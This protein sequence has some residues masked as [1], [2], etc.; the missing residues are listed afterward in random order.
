[1]YSVIASDG[2]QYGPVDLST[3]QQWIQEGRIV[4]DTVILDGVTGNRGPA[5]QFPLIAPHLHQG[6][7]PTMYQPQVINQ[8]HQPGAHYPGG[9]AYQ[10]GQYSQPPNPYAQ[11]PRPG[12]QAYNPNA[13]QKVPAAL[14]AFFL[15][16]FGAHKFYLGHTT[17]GIVMLLVTILT[18]GYGGLITGIWALYDFVMIL[19][20]KE[21]DANGYPLV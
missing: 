9:G 11:Y 8:V 3:I 1:M 2:N 7:P 13:K 21:T 12:M 15:G 20:D 18:C 19:C 14:L 6:A 4:A 16:S 10:Q 5:S 17:L